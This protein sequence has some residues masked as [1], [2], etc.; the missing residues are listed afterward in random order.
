MGPEEVIQHVVPGKVSLCK[1]D[2][3]LG[4]NDHHM[5]VTIS[6][7]MM[8]FIERVMKVL[9]KKT[10]DVLREGFGEHDEGSVLVDP[11]ESR[12]VILR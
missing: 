9:G 6:W 10:R 11:C 1:V 12:V 3:G 4:R 7:V 8:L 2:P 5:K